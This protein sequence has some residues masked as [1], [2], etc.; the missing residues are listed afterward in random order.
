MEDAECVTVSSVESP[1]RSPVPAVG[2]SE[3]DDGPRS[4]ALEP[5]VVVLKRERNP[6]RRARRRKKKILGRLT[7]ITEMAISDPSQKTGV[8]MLSKLNVRS[9]ALRDERGRGREAHMLDHLAI[10]NLLRLW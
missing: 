10:L 3:E 9:L 7:H 6:S 8:A 2:W 5:W 1:Y 4:F